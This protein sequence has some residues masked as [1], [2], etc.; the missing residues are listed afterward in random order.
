M[1]N[2]LYINLEVIGFWVNFRVFEENSV[3]KVLW[4]YVIGKILKE[5]NIFRFV[6]EGLREIF[7]K[8]I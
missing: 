1:Y 8:N 4:N 2:I 5:L 7:K 6:K 3:F